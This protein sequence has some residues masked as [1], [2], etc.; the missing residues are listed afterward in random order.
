MVTPGTFMASPGGTQNRHRGESSQI[1]CVKN[2]VALHLC[3]E[4][5]TDI[6][7][8][9][10]RSRIMMKRLIVIC[11]MLAMAVAPMRGQQI[12]ATGGEAGLTAWWKLDEGTGTKAVDATDSG[13]N[14]T[15]KNGPTWVKGFK[16]NALKFDGTNDYVAIDKLRYK[17]K[18]IA[19]TWIRTSKAVD[20]IVASFDRDQYW[21][22][23]I[24]GNVAGDGQIGWLVMTD[25]GLAGVRSSARVDDGAWHHVA[26]VFDNGKMTVYVDGV[27]DTSGTTGRSFGTG[28]TRYGFLGIGS[29][30]DKFDGTKTSSPYFNGELDDVRIYD[31]ALAKTDIQQLALRGPANDMSV[32]ATAVGEVDKLTFD[33]RDATFDG[34]GLYIKS[35][36]VWYSYT[37]S[38][39]GRATVSLAGSEFDTILAVYRGAQANPGKDRFLAFNDDFTGLASQV[40]FDAVA[41]QVYLIEI[42]GFNT[43]HGKGF[44]TITC[45]GVTPAEYDL[46]DAPDGSNHAGKRMTAYTVAGQTAI[47]GNFPTVFEAAAGKPRGPLHRDPLSVAVLGP[48][49]TFEVEA[50]KK[51][52][53]DSSNNINPARDEADKDAGDDGVVLPLVL[54]DGE[55]ASF[56]YIV[57]V[58]KPDSELW[59]N[60]WFDWNRDGDWDDNGGTYPAM[61][62]GDE[63]VSEWA[64]QNQYLCGLSIGTHKLRTPGFLAWHLDKG[65]EKVW[66]RITLS[67]QPWTGGATPGVLGNGGSGPIDGYET[68]ETED[69][70]IAPEGTC[71]LCQ[72]RNDDGKIDFD[73]LIELMYL[74]MDC[75][76]E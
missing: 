20:Q 4:A 21:Q 60:V 23:V 37:P 34:Q 44:L 31:R 62:V 6:L 24:N 33:T 73:D 15:L 22:L 27:A 57:T 53:E 45:Q 17:G 3:G 63:K 65:P 19:A 43:V 38:V 13:Y 30:A 12:E 75:C 74:W 76:T 51:A 70:L 71:S 41:G 49:V 18:G 55:F 8:M 29:Q 56:E 28:A 52:D 25:A 42:G 64:V 36:N 26:A 59:V 5:P 35:P 9:E 48:S 47:Q 67:E 11:S 61:T 14:G 54:P 69:Y 39:T 1:Q 7:R 10:I 72:D 2:R 66:M 46:G 58:I 68:G 50:D 32:D 40:E 16:G